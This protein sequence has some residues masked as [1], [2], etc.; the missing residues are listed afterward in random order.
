MT[1]VQHFELIEG[2]DYK[3]FLQRIFA[4][5]SPGHISKI[6]N[7]L[8]LIVTELHDRPYSLTATI[9]NDGIE[10]V[11]LHRGRQL[12]KMMLHIIDDLFDKTRYHQEDQE[13]HKL[14]LKLASR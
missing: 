10:F 2:E 4:V 7:L 1:K 13:H 6:A 11:F 12:D 3:D 5:W 8:E 14:I 9:N